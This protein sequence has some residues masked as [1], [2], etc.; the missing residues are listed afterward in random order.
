MIAEQ[1]VE[2][3]ERPFL[4]RIELQLYELMLVLQTV[5]SAENQ[6]P[7][8]TYLKQRHVLLSMPLQIKWQLRDLLEVYL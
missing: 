4:E 7:E 3:E 2:C 5:E 1:Q 8:M 6:A